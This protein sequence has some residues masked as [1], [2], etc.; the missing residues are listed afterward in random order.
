MPEKVEHKDSIKLWRQSYSRPDEA[1]YSHQCSGDA[2]NILG[3][4]FMCLSVYVSV[5]MG[6]FFTMGTGHS[7]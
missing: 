5:C 7:N 1:A 3:C 6:L 2:V 4:F